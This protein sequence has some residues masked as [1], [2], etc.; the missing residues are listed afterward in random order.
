MT[1]VI[2]EEGNLTIDE[3]LSVTRGYAKI[4]VSELAKKKME[5]SRKVVDTCVKEE[6]VVYGLTTG[7]GKF[8]DVTISEED[9]MAL[10]ENLIM[11]HACGV[12]NPLPEEVVRGMMLLR[13]N[14]LCIGYSGVQVNT[15]LTLAEMLNKG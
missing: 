13:I 8:S 14:A 2:I 6:K 3:F 1:T 7:F 15:V 5:E 11:S 4:E 9:S 10:Q 12:G